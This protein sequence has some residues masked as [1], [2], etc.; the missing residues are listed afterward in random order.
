[1]PF[2]DISWDNLLS[3]LEVSNMFPFFIAFHIVFDSF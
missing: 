3:S 2:I 1:M